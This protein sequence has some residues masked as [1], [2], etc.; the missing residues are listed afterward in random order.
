M[1]YVVALK[2]MY[3]EF[4]RALWNGMGG[5]NKKG[6]ADNPALPFKRMLSLLGFGTGFF[7]C[8]RFRCLVNGFN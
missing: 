1:N 2:D 6:S 8:F 7:W 3:R 5:C 4:Q